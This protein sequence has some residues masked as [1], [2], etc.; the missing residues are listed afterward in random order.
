[1]IEL[2]LFGRAQAGEPYETLLQR[3]QRVAARFPRQVIVREYELNSDE[4]RQLGIARAP[5]LAIGGTLRY[6]GTIPTAGQISAL[7]RVTVRQAQ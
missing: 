2:K 7:L 1:M 3:T 6:V 4:A 5:A